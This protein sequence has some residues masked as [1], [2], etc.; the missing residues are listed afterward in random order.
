M[1]NKVVGI[2]V[3]AGPP[4][5]PPTHFER[6][7]SIIPIATTASVQKIVTENAK[8]PASTSNPGSP[9]NAETMEQMVHAMPIPKNT[10]TALLPVTL[11]ILESAY[12]S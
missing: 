4:S 2:L 10:L 6:L 11:P 7:S 9:R 3:I 12:L 8:V 5:S 1:K